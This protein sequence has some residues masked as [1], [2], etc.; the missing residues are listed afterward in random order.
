MTEEEGRALAC[1]QW[2][3]HAVIAQEWAGYGVWEDLNEVRKAVLTEVAY[4]TR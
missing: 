2:A 4:P 1:Q 3:E